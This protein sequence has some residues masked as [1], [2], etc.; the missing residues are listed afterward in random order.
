[1]NIGQQRHHGHERSRYPDRV[2]HEV[3]GGAGAVAGGDDLI[4][5][6]AVVVSRVLGVG[7]GLERRLVDH[8]LLDADAAAAARSATA[9]PED[10]PHSD[11][12]P[13]RAAISAAM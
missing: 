8:E 3:L 1:L 5:P 9:P 7:V 11:S 2:S 10:Q 4:E 12:R 6:R 13:P